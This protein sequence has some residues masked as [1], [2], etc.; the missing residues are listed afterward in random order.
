MVSALCS[1]ATRS[2]SE[3]SPAALEAP[4]SMRPGSAAAA[5]PHGER[6]RGVLIEAHVH[7]LRQLVQD[8]VPSVAQVVGLLP[9]ALGGADLAV[10]VRD[11]RSVLVHLRDVGLDLRVDLGPN[12]LERAVERVEEIDQRLRAGHDALLEGAVLGMVG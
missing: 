4:A 12:P 2:A 9:P 8:L 5:G 1:P 6:A 7:Q 11:L 3:L 10:Q